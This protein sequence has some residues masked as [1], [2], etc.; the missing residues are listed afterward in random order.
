LQA[1]WVKERLG[2]PDDRLLDDF[3]LLLA[4]GS[5]LCGVAAYRFALRRIWWTWP[6]FLLSITPGFRSLLDFSYRILAR[7]RHRVSDACGFR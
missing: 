5:H 3:R 6:L 1:E 4:D 7:N 2:I